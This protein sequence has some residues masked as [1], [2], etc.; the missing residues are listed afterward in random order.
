MSG[1]AAVVQAALVTAL[2]AH[3]PLAGAVS[4]IFLGPPARA[5]FPYVA[6][7]GAATGDWSHKTGRGREHR[8]AVSLWDDDASRAIRLTEAIEAAIEAVPS[9]L[10]GHRIVSL[11]MIRTRLLRERGDGPWVGIVEYRARTLEDAG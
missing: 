6:I 4:G 9:A 8:L 2:R 5:A 11:T 7:G 10:D 3:P 1:A